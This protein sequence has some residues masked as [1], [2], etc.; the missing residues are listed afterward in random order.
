MLLLFA[1]F[2]GVSQ[3]Q[4]L[5][6][7]LQNKSKAAKGCA[8]RWV[9]GWDMYS[10]MYLQ[11]RLSSVLVSVFVSV[12]LALSASLRTLG[13]INLIYMGR[14]SGK[15]LARSF[16]LPSP[17]LPLALTPSLS[18][19]ALHCCESINSNCGQE[20][21]EICA[22]F[23]CTFPAAIARL[24]ASV[25]VRQCVCV[26]AGICVRQCMCVIWASLFAIFPRYSLVQLN[27]TG[28]SNDFL[29]GK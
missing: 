17:F 12:S 22:N 11:L 18:L 16:T 23:Y 7:R 26:C 15:L 2:Y 4:S 14:Q 28:S 20:K 19:S 6:S 21:H 9:Y 3:R 25:G 27:A 5:N 24:T 13:R 8:C 1:H 29:C 10:C